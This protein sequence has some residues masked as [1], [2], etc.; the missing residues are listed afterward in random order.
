VG[1]RYYYNQEGRAQHGRA[2]GS[3]V[4]NYLAAELHTEMLRTAEFVVTSPYPSLE[5]YYAYR[6]DYTPTLNL[7]WGMQRRLGHNFLFDLNAGVGVGPT[8]S[9]AH[10]GG[11]SAGGLNLST[12][13]NL[14]VYF[15]H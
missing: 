11:Y 15:G 6:T 2:R 7:L 1:G 13:I 14:G 12:Q 5:G 10:F 4:G 8:R 3:F 9:D